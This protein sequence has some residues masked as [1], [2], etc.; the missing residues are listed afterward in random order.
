MHSE[1]YRV[2]LGAN[3]NV[4]PTDLTWMPRIDCSGETRLALHAPSSLF[5]ERK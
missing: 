1:L 3:K 4:V 5:R 2:I